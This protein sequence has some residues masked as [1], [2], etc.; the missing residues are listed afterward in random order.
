MSVKSHSLVLLIPFIAVSLF[1][2]TKMEFDTKVF[3]CGNVIEGKTEKIYATFVVKNT[4]DSMLVLKNV[5]PGCGCT[6]VK[7]DS[8]I[9][10]GKTAKIEAAV[11]IANYHSGSISKYI[12]VTS[13]A[14]NK[15]GERLTIEATIIPVIDVSET[16]INLDG[17][18]T[19]KVK[20]VVLASKKADLKVT[21]VAFKTPSQPNTPEWRAEIPL[22]LKYTWTPSDSIRADGYHVFKLTIYPPKEEKTINGEMVIKTNHPDKPEIT[23]NTAIVK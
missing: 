9:G 4:G 21:E 8:L 10:A 15:D 2:G 20:T 6:V 11:N 23:I 19:S 12:T 7:Y 1:A 17:G 13:N 18:D 16:Y 5:R 3:K 14:E 22:P